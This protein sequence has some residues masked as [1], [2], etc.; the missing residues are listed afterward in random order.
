MKDKSLDGSMAF[1]PEDVERGS[2]TKFVNLL[3][4][5]DYEFRV[6]S[7]GYCRIVDYISRSRAEYGE[8]FEIWTEEDLDALQQDAYC[9]AMYDMRHDS[10]TSAMRD[11]YAAKYG[12]HESE[13]ES[14]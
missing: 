10:V 1:T 14:E 5:M 4:K 7:D 13:E 9:D 11:M 12:Q 8:H 6:W 3:C 2:F